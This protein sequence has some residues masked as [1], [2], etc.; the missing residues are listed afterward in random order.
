MQDRIRR[1]VDDRT[2]MLAAISHDLRTPITRMRLRAEFV[3]DDEQR[4][5]MLADLE[6]MEHMIAATLA[7]AR[8]DATREERK[9][10]D[11]AD[12]VRDLAEDVGIAYDGPQSLVAPARPLALKRAVANILDNA[13]KYGGDARVNL[14]CDSGLLTICVDDSGPGIAEADQEKVFAP[15]IRLE[16]SRNRDTGGTGLGLAVARAAIR[17]HGGD[18]I[19]K[20]RPEGGLRVILSFPVG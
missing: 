11:V 18:I 5:K 2:Q 6:E 16:T 12:L 14:S 19:L 17:A 15:F 1:F 10:V 20:N 4:A 9:P 8:D 7:F 3:E 13:R